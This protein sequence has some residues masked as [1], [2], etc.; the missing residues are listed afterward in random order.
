MA[1]VPEERRIAELRRLGVSEALMRLS[2]GDCVHE[3]FRDTCLGP[4]YYVYHGAGVPAGPPLVP[5]W[6]RSLNDVVVGIWE[7]PDGLEFIEFSIEA[8]DEYTPLARTEQGFWA[9]PFDFFFE[10]D[11]PAQKMGEAA[12]AVGF[13][14]L[15]RL[16]AAREAVDSRLTTFEAHRTWL[17]AFVAGI[18]KDVGGKV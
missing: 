11:A 18:D 7:R 12:A 3:L 16:R 4:P 10:S 14:F 17:Q 15:D 13:H 1:V 8:N 5:L 2:R 9:T 6:D